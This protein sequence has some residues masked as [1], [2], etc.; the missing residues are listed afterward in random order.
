MKLVIM[1]LLSIVFSLATAAAQ[2]ASFTSITKPCGRAAALSITGLPKLGT[3]FTVNNIRTPALCTKK[4][5]GCQVGPCNSCTGNVL[6]FGIVRI[7]AP[8]GA[9]KLHVQP[10]L[11]L[12]GQG[13]VAFKV[14]NVAA[15]IGFKFLL[16]RADVSMIETIDANCGKSYPISNVNGLSDA[17][18]GLVGR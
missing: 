14:P 5:C 9:C 4:F 17:V 10:F 13:S 12:G 7:N 6:V 8:L 18:Q 11:L 16:Q 15:A 3:T 1:T 2:T